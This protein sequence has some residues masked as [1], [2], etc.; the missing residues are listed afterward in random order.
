LIDALDKKK[1]AKDG[2]DG[3][4]LRVMYSDQLRSWVIYSDRATDGLMLL[5][6]VIAEFA[7]YLLAMKTLLL[8]TGTVLRSRIIQR[9]R[10]EAIPAIYKLVRHWWAWTPPQSD[11]QVSA[12]SGYQKQSSG[13]IAVVA[14]KPIRSALG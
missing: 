1:P 5:G 13:I 7:S 3:L 9:K 4:M 8:F 6:L 2:P 10:L 12:V 14:K 11:Y